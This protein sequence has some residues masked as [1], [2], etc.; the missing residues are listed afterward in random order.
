MHANNS[1]DY[2]FRAD[3]TTDHGLSFTATL[4]YETLTYNINTA[5]V[6]LLTL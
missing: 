1:S 4:M 5:F 2:S 3:V 6:Q